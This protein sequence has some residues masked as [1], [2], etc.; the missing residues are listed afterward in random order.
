MFPNNLT[1]VLVPGSRFES[2][3][4]N[5]EAFVTIKQRKYF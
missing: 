1:P 5:L 3:S 2:G 4:N